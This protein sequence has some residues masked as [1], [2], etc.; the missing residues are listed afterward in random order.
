M[1]CVVNITSPQTRLVPPSFPACF[2]VELR[3]P[4]KAQLYRVYVDR[5]DAKRNYIATCEA[6]PAAPQGGETGGPAP[7]VGRTEWYVPPVDFFNAGANFDSNNSPEAFVP[8]VV[9]EWLTCCD[10]SIA[11][12]SEFCVGEAE[13]DLRAWPV[14]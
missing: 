5:S 8:Q 4:H 7:I 10:G 12:C 11:E 2:G 1:H 9:V 14:W 3:F 13:R 6:I